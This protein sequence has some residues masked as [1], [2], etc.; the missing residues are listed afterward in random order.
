MID[1]QLYVPVDRLVARA[2]GVR[3]GGDVASIARAV[4]DIVDFWKQC[5]C[6]TGSTCLNQAEATDKLKKRKKKD[7]AVASGDATSGGGKT[8]K[9]HKESR[10][11]DADSGFNGALNGKAWSCSLS[12]FRFSFASYAFD[13]ETI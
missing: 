10:Q 7:K 13:T 2:A 3:L 4:V 8:K 6:L 9:K 11:L 5:C 12:R 1:I